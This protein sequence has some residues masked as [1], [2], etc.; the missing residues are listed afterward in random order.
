V[1]PITEQLLQFIWQ[2]QLLNASQLFTTDNLPIQ[3]VK[4]GV[5][6]KNQGP[7]F[8][9]ATIQ[10][11]GITLVGNIEI[12]TKASHWLQHNTSRMPTT[13]N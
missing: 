1:T 10:V 4:P 2:H 13:S 5:F 6:N 9:H 8:L 12:H 7:D 3:V 11:D